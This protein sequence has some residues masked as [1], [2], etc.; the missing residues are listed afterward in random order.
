MD[1]QKMKLDFLQT[2]FEC[3][4]RRDKEKVLAYA[5]ELYVLAKIFE[6]SSPNLAVNCYERVATTQE[7]LRMM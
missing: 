7:I 2:M 6:S 4:E 1:P 5:R 3:I